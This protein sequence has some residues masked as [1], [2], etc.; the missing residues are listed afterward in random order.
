MT[1]DY[2]RFVF[3]A[4][5]RKMV[6]DF[7]GMY[8]AEDKEWFDSWQS[9]DQRNLRHQICSAIFS[10]HNF[11]SILEV[12]CGK[13]HAI[14][15][16]KK[17]NNRVIGIDIAPTAIA[18]A[19]AAYPDIDFRCLRA[20]AIGS[21]NERFDL[22]TFQ[23]VFAYVPLWQTVLETAARMTNY[24]LV[25]EYI[26]PE[27]IGYVKSNDDL[28][29]AF[30]RHFEVVHKVILNNT[31]SIFFGTVNRSESTSLYKEK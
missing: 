11:N 16:L 26:P 27:P 1:G 12:G 24:C 29:T 23:T 30:R 17:Q 3:D 2:H 9:A 18:K 19:K 4:D 21:L 28:E 10:Q 5:Q 6:G 7:E 13:G 8:A 25:A 22:V 31:F 14:A 15:P 20:E